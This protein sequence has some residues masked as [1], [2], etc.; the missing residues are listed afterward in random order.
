M[1]I[2]SILMGIGLM[3]VVALYVG[4]PFLKGQ[5]ER[6]EAFSKEEALLA[7]KEALL[8]QIRV[9]DFEVE[10]GK[11][12]DD[13]YQRQRSHLLQ[14]AASVL[15][16]LDRLGADPTTGNGVT[17]RGAADVEADIEAAIAA[18]RRASQEGS[19]GA[20]AGADRAAEIEAAVQRLRQVEPAQDG[21]QATGKITAGRFCSQCGNPRDAGD[22]FCA[23]CGF[24]FA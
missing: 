11:M 16:D 19:T 7:Q 22:R 20:E 23:Y 15:R 24:R 4:R 17:V 8:A 14:T 21:A 2:G 5:P 13:E 3:F 9:L 12:P 6:R 18:A 1:G 10:T